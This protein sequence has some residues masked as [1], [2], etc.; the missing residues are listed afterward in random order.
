[1][2]LL[3]GAI[4]ATL[5]DLGIHAVR[6]QGRSG[7][8][9]EHDGVHNKVAAIGLRVASGVTM[10]GFAIN[11]SNSLEPYEHITACGISDAGV[12]TVSAL[13]GR[14]VSPKELAPIV[15]NHLIRAL[16]E[17]GVTETTRPAFTAPEAA[18]I[19]GAQHTVPS[20]TLV[21]EATA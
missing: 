1:M 15:R 4:I 3:E 16:A 20:A 9:V 6:V 10:H 11:C 21:K 19:P 14:E 7:V 8:W 17:F 12:T 2:R 18:P 13:A 5:D